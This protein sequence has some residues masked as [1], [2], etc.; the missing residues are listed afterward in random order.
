MPN[1]IAK[2]GDSPATALQNFLTL[3]SKQLVMALPDQLRARPERFIRL[4]T[5]ALVTTPQLQNCGMLSICNSVMLAAQLGLEPNN[6]LGHGWLIP[7]AK[8]CTFQP[9]YRGLLDLGYRAESFKSAQPQVVYVGDDFDYQEGATPR[10]YHKPSPPS[11]RAKLSDKDEDYD[12]I[13]AYC[14]VTLLDG[15][16]DAMWMWREEIEA[17]RSKASRAGENSPWVKWYWEMVRKTP[18]KRHM[19]F[20]RLSPQAALGVGIDDQAE[21]FH[22][23]D[24]SASRAPL[25]AQDS[26]IDGLMEEQALAA[27]DVLRGSREQQ[28]QVA[29]QKIEQGQQEAARRTRQPRTTKPTP[30]R[31]EEQQRREDFGPNGDG[32]TPGF[33]VEQPSTNPIE[34]YRRKVTPEAFAAILSKAREV[35][36]DKGTHFYANGFATSDDVSVDAVDAIIFDLEDEIA[37]AKGNG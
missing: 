32:T 26:V 33:F 20:L 29:T 24:Y 22:A 5:T 31:S 21:A 36:T 3:N 10:L 7:Y 27:E 19:K 13:G 16:I 4:A 11:R 1:E 17:V 28:Q 6:G 35:I 15:S 18:V 12:W 23:K 8:V 37:R 30:T 34:A 9:G 2:R 25:L 14:R